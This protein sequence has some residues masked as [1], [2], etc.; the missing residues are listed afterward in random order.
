MRPSSQVPVETHAA[1]YG[2]ALII[3]FQPEIRRA[4]AHVGQSPLFS[5]ISLEAEAKSTPICQDTGT[6][7]YFVTLPVGVSMRMVEEAIIDAKVTSKTEGTDLSQ[8][9]QELRSLKRAID[10]TIKTAPQRFV[11]RQLQHLETM[12]EEVKSI[13]PAVVNKKGELWD[14]AIRI[15]QRMPSLQKSETGQAEAF[16]VFSPFLVGHCVRPRG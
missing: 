13:D 9:V 8:K 11:S 10:Q 5:S 3:I 2:V 1:I 16:H 6:N 7:L 15:Y 14:T 12:V 4:L